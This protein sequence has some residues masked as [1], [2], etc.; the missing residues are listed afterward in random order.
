M[1]GIQQ[2]L[3]KRHL[4]PGEG[5]HN[6]LIKY[7]SPCELIPLVYL[8]QPTAF[9]LP[10]LAITSPISPRFAAS[11]KLLYNYNIYN[12]SENM[13]CSVFTVFNFN[14]FFLLIYFLLAKNILTNNRFENKKSHLK[15]TNLI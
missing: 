9:M 4:N 1:K 7:D 11:L 15:T 5:F 13:I 10:T 2:K 8:S 14:Y 12:F 3:L 6:I